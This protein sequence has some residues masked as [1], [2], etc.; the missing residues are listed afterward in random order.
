MQDDNSV[1]CPICKT[2]T[3]VRVIFETPVMFIP[4]GVG[5]LPKSVATL[6]NAPI[7][8]C[9]SPG[10]A[11]LFLDSLGDRPIVE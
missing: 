10:C 3:I 8:K 2:G 11:R 7:F 4:T 9:S 1:F 5:I 6:G